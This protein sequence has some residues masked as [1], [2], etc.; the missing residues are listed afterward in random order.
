[1][2]TVTDTVFQVIPLA[3][4]HESPLNPRKRFDP[5]KLEEL[6]ASAKE[7]GIRTPLIVRP[8]ADGF[9]I[10]AGHR[11]FRAAS[12]AGLATVPAIVRDM[13]DDEFLELLNFENLQR[14]DV[15][16]LEEADGYR[17]LMEKSGHDVDTIAAKIGKSVS[18]VYQRLKLADLT[19]KVREAFLE[20]KITAG[21]AILIARLQPKD[22]VEALKATTPHWQDQ[23]WSVRQLASWIQSRIVMDLTKAPF[24]PTD[25]TLV[26]KAGACG[27]CPKRAGANPDLWGDIA[28][29]D[30]CMDAACFQSKVEAWIERRRVEAKKQGDGLRVVDVAAAY[31]NERGVLGAGQWAEAG[32]RICKNRAMAV[33]VEA[34]PNGKGSRGDILTVCT[35]PHECD[36]HSGRKT[37]TR[38]P[39][40]RSSL[41]PAK[42]KPPAA[43]E[44]VGQRVLAA[45]WKT[46]WT[47]APAELRQAVLEIVEYGEAVVVLAT[48]FGYTFRGTHYDPEATKLLKKKIATMG[49]GDLQRLIVLER[50]A[51]DGA[52][53]D[54]LSARLRAFAKAHKVDVGAIEKAV[55]A[56][57][58]ATKKT[59]AK[60]DKKAGKAKKK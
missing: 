8:N 52:G 44:L 23:P 48:I 41:A 14:E 2:E 47:P 40:Y 56:E 46:S 27:P 31:T 49:A 3:K 19:A 55:T 36:A 38:T 10:A 18:Y 16:P 26:K 39:A 45:L 5:K 7:H 29:G 42:P 1:M 51:N 35:K 13:T 60:K 37:S 15:H 25:A 43:E 12:A 32:D 30:R 28:N 59:P 17:T 22:Q 53:G 21:H 6:T 9:E 58:E 24:D 20:E 33:L 11:R 57:L 50:I 34:N 4:L 54:P